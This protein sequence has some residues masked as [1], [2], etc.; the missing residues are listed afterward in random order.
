MYKIQFYC[1]YYSLHLSVL[2][3]PS[4]SYSYNKH[5]SFTYN[6]YFLFSHV[7]MFLLLVCW[8]KTKTLLPLDPSG[9][10]DNVCVAPNLL[11]LNFTED[12]R[13]SLGVD[14]GTERG[15]SEAFGCMWVPSFQ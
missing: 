9:C 15:G 12:L 4:I 7:L 14:P 10:S 6:T 3:F 1:I 2:I 8:N 13:F 5:I 11:F